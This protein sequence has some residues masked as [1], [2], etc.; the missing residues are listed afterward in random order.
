MPLA[1]YLTGAVGI[2]FF[3]SAPQAEAAV[4]S[5]TF[6]VS[7]LNQST[8]PLYNAPTSPSLGG[9]TL[10]GASNE[11]AF[12][13]TYGRLWKPHFPQAQLSLG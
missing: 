7:V 1:A 8:G 3:V 11:V 4:T 10:W 9:L 2:S 12:F 5:V 13:N 6:P